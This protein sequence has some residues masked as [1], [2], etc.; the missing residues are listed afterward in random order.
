MKA[1][2]PAAGLGTR[3]FPLSLACPKEM[4][5][6]GR[7]PAL[8]HVVEEAVEAGVDTL[9][10][11]TAASKTSITRYFFEPLEDTLPP[12]CPREPLDEIR[13]ITDRMDIV[14]IH[15]KG[16]KGLGHA[17]WSA[18]SVV[19]DEPFLIMLPDDIIRP[20][21]T[22]EMV[23]LGA[24]SGQGVLVV[25]EVPEAEVS[26]YG[27]VDY[28]GDQQPLQIV[29]A[30]EKPLAHL[31]PSHM[32][33]L[34]RYLLP[35]GSMSLMGTVGVG[36]GGEIQLTSCLDLIAKRDGLLG[37]T[38][39]ASRHLDL[40]SMDGYLEANVRVALEDPELRRRLGL[41]LH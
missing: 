14:V 36:H 26:R 15:Q 12:G 38:L 5:P 40:G 19:G 8:H 31:A 4:L 39:E 27:I 3:L 24:S 34:G 32:A 16:A 33:I 22:K 41:T 17:V 23:A 37:I 18:H 25:K 2:I 30:V 28:R 10:L 20:S 21:I 1:V 29:G 35:A 6:L 11:I 9:V 13:R 7:K